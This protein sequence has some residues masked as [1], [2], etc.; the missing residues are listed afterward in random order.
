MK[1]IVVLSKR[2]ALWYGCCFFILMLNA[3]GT[4]QQKRDTTYRQAQTM[5]ELQ[6]PD[7]LKKPPERRAITD[8]PEELDTGNIPDNLEQPPTVAGINLEQEEEKPKSADSEDEESGEETKKTLQ[9]E[10]KAFPDNTQMLL[11]KGDIDTVWPRVAKAV[12]KIGFTIDD[13]NRGKFYYSIS[14]KFE[15]VQTIPDQSEV[16]EFDQETPTEEHL[17]YVEPGEE[18]IEITIRNK[19]SKTEGTTLANQLLQQMKGYIEQ[20]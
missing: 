2:P 5:P 14:R 8:V 4:N 6:V 19:Q 15:R 18:N 7:D 11:V 9:S 12:K 17:V 16:V 1:R 20:P 3:C 10:I 13:S